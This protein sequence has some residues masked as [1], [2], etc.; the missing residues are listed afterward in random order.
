VVTLS[1]PTVAGLR[2]NVGCGA[3]PTPGW[4][5]YDNSFAVRAAKWQW[6]MRGLRRARLLNEHSWDLV[7]VANRQ[8]IRFAN[9]AARIP[10]P[11]N[12][13]DAVYSS[14]MIE[15]L[16]RREACAF[17]IEA[18]RVL[19]P[20]GVLRLAAP[21]LALLIGKYVATGDADAFVEDI[22]MGQARPAGLLPRAKFA[23]VGPRHHLWMYDGQSLSRL[24]G[25]AGFADVA[26]MPAGKTNI[27]DPE[28]LDLEERAEESV[29]VE[30]VKR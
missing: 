2:V 29:Y 26:V 5:N 24:L 23:F 11:D 25:D 22:Y 12:S 19:R 15:H 1:R 28:G 10:C 21:D 17:L 16:D 7:R 20:G 6:A 8:D 18:G 9:A 30:A 3:T 13:A 14:H 4:L 27:A